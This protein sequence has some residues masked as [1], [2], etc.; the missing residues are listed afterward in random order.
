MLEELQLEMARWSKPASPL[1]DLSAEYVQEL[2]MENEGLKS[3][4]GEV[5]VSGIELS[6]IGGTRE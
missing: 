5:A 2:R 6:V 3:L 1:G 4:Q